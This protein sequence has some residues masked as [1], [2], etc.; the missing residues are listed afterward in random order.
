MKN[1]TK[2][3]IMLCS[4][5]LGIL[6]GLAV[7]WLFVR[8][9]GIIFDLLKLSRKQLLKLNKTHKKAELKKIY[10]RKAELWV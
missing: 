7:D 5:E 8:P 10:L 3:Q 4:L 6:L 9:L 1:R 2:N